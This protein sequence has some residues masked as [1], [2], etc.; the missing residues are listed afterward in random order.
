MNNTYRKILKLKIE[1]FLKEYY[2]SQSIFEDLDK[3]NNLLHAGEYGTYRENI[4]NELIKFAIPSKF[5]TDTGFLLNS[6]D[7][8]STQCDILIFDKNNTPLIEM[9]SKTRFFPVEPVV[10]VGEIKSKLKTN[11]LC[12]A[13][14][15]LAKIK[16]LK[17][18]TQNVL[19][20]NNPTKKGF[21]PDI[22]CHDTMFSFLILEKIGVKRF[23]ENKLFNAL[24]EAYIDAGIEYQYRHNVILSLE[25][26]VLSY[27]N[28]YDD[29]NKKIPQGT[30]MYMPKLGYRNFSNCIVEKD[31]YNNVTYFLS[32]LSNFLINVNVYYPEPNTYK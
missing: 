32:S 30:K 26:G 18:I 13:A 8:V 28:Q 1:T 29:L 22:D 17:Q 25:D 6:N 10:G 12:S 16:R 19:C 24:N 7:E 31:H 3:H 14:V 21:N 27:C 2:A 15:K 23:D 9:D 4:C 5:E 11:E 20:V